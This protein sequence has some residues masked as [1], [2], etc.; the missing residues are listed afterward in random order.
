MNGF[1]VIDSCLSS[2]HTSYRGGWAGYAWYSV[3]ENG[4]K[5]D[6]FYPVYVTNKSEKILLKDPTAWNFIK[7]SGPLPELSE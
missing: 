4:K 6:Y 1:P 7:D 3:D 2:E 5:V